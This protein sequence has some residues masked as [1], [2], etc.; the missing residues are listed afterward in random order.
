M[1]RKGRRSARRDR[2]AAPPPAPGASTHKKPTLWQRFLGLSNGVKAVLALIG[3]ILPILTFIATKRDNFESRLEAPAARLRSD[4][5]AEWA[6]AI[7]DLERLGTSDTRAARVAEHLFQFV[8]RHALVTEMPGDAAPCAHG[9]TQ[10]TYTRV[11]ADVEAAVIA[12]ARML[13]TAGDSVSLHGAYLP[14][15]T[16]LDVPLRPLLLTRS[17]LRAASLDELGGVQLDSADLTGAHLADADLTDAELRFALLPGAD[18]NGATL[19]GARLHGATL[20]NANLRFSDLSF[21]IAPEADFS[22]ADLYC[23]DLTFA[24]LEAARFDSVHNW[25]EVWKF[26]NAFL[27]DAHGLDSART[28]AATAGNASFDTI[29]PLQRDSARAQAY[30]QRGTQTDPCRSNP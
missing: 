22:S 29:P 27:H 6:Q 21:A 20:S 5:A 8:R 2:D 17:C 7:T 3:A 19:T 24:H 10:R 30:R 28:N 26:T 11:P 13:R 18:L 14:G 4:N 9:A 1:A 23:A 12:L 25:L 16:A 15:L